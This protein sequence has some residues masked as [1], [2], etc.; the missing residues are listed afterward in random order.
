MRSSRRPP[1][2]RFAL[3]LCAAAA[4]AACGGGHDD[5][6]SAAADP[7]LALDG[8]WSPSVPTDHGEGPG[9]ASGWWSAPR[10]AT[11]A[12]AGADAHRLGHFDDA[13]GWP[14]MPIHVLLLPDGRV[15]SFGTTAT[16][17]PNSTANRTPQY[18]IW[19]PDLGTQAGAHLLLPNQT[20]ANIFCAGQII[21]PGLDRVLIAGGDRVVG[22][23]ANYGINA[24]SFF[25]IRSNTMSPGTAVMDKARWYPTP[26]VLDN[27]DVLILGGRVDP[28]PT[29]A[30]TPE[31]FSPATGWRTLPGAT[32]E[33]AYGSLNWSYPKAWLA[34]NRKV[35][36]LSKWGGTF[37]LDPNGAGAL[38]QTPVTLP[39]L[40]AYFP[41]VMY[42][43]GKILST[44]YGGKVRLIDLNGNTPLATVGPSLSQ[45]RYH[46]NATV[47]ADGRVAFTGGSAAFNLVDR[48]A[49]R[50][51]IWDPA[52]GSW[53]LGAAA[54]KMR[55]YHSTALLLPDARVLTAGG[56]A[57]GPVNNLN[58]EIYT[59]SYLYKADGSGALAPRPL[60]QSAPATVRWNTGFTV[61]VDSP[62]SRVTLVRTGAVTHSIDFDQ[63]FLD[64][65]YTQQGGQVQVQSPGSSAVA[66]P[67][68]YLLFVFNGQKVPS[69]AKII[70]LIDNGAPAPARRPRRLRCL[71]LLPQPLPRRFPPRRRR[72]YPAPHRRP[73]LPAR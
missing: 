53:S 27:G 36:V 32:S 56:G 69:V 50:V 51:E 71:R 59:P 73:R 18:D 41:A 16:P 29:S 2:V 63:R 19:T 9:V 4:L 49:Y 30:P 12:V 35:F 40:D 39:S 64:L 28:V 37:Y 25:D 57:P 34:P 6:A 17:D 44:H 48:V 38:A 31:R 21:V 23:V 20:S 24:V 60:I 55:L 1:A 66:P 8:L 13:F 45:E 58:A 54:S 47:L 43:P 11:A 33:A 72:L 7:A 67:G 62:V 22:G 46:A 70:K 14:L 10:V 61:E 15:M 3:S 26:V 68:N 52:T 42:A 65:G 5:E